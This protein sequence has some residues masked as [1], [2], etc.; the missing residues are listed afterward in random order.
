[1]YFGYAKAET[2]NALH[3]D[4]CED[5]IQLSPELAKYNPGI[6]YRDNKNENKYAKNFSCAAFKKRRA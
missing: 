2:A 5:Y 6:E 4:C 1:M 3:Y